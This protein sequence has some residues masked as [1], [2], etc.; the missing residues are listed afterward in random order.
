[1]RSINS[2]Q[3]WTVPVAAIRSCRGASSSI[4]AA[5]MNNLAEARHWPGGKS[6]AKLLSL[7]PNRDARGTSALALFAVLALC[8]GLGCS[9]RSTPSVGEGARPSPAESVEARAQRYWDFRRDK[10]LS[11]AYEMYCSDYRARVS[12]VEYLKMTRLVRFDL[13]DLRVTRAEGDDAN[14]NV[15]VAFRFELPTLPGQIAT[16]ETTDKW[17]RDA[18]GQWCKVDEQLIMPF[19]TTPPQ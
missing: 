9:S 10:D 19:P 16:S 15:T 5:R 6:R 8:S 18:D 4:L 13:Q 14:T 2:V 17:K 12:R 1:M 11:G 7:L 3:W